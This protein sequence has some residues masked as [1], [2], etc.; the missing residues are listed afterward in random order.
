MFFCMIVS[1]T[2]TFRHDGGH[3]ITCGLLLALCLSQR[4]E[5]QRQNNE[6]PGVCTLLSIHV[7]RYNELLNPV[8]M[9]IYT[10]LNASSSRPIVI[11]PFLVINMTYII[12]I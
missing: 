12:V 5:S 9:C 1:A 11:A 8:L 6:I 4:P 7:I 3:S 10:I 2:A